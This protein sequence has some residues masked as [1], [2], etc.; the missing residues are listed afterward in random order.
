V[1][2]YAAGRDAFPGVSP[3][4]EQLYL[5]VIDGDCGTGVAA[6]GGG[7]PGPAGVRPSLRNVSMTSRR[8]RVG[9]KPT[10]VAARKKVPVGTAFRFTLNESATLTI[11]IDRL[12]K[13]RRVKKRC[14][15]PTRKRR[16]RKLCQRATKSGALTRRNL[17]AGPGKVQFSGRLG[18][19]KLTPG[20]Y[21]ATLTAAAAGVKS[22]PVALRFSIVR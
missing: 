5:R 15:Q 11:R 1:S 6:P 18:T 20:N 9:R 4:F 8:F 16:H 3:D 22:T 12:T 14:L 17:P 19:R 21:R 10:V 13:G 7:G 2:Y